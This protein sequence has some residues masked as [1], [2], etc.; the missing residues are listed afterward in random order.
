M[1]VYVKDNS[2]HPR[3]PI[4]GLFFSAR[5][6]YLRDSTRSPFGDTKIHL[7]A[8]RLLDPAQFN[9]YFADFYCNWS[10][11]NIHYV[12]IVICRKGSPS[13]IF[14]GQHLLKLKT[15]TNFL[16]A[17]S[18]G[19]Q[20]Y[21]EEGRMFVELFFTED[22]DISAEY[23]RRTSVDVTGYGRSLGDVPNNTKCTHC[24]INIDGE[25]N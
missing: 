6:S 9:Y 25:S 12:T 19:Y 24:N 11:R 15:E 5:P 1:E 10:T 23:E 13:D 3:S 4:N 20:I 22:V 18:D 8:H 17:N 16:R 2:G 21:F 14:C 7:D